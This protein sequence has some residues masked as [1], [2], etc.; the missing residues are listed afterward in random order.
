MN[1]LKHDEYKRMYAVEVQNQ[2][3]ALGKKETDQGSDLEVVDR[4]W[5][6]LKTSM[7]QAAKKVL[8]RKIE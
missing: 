8:Q 5:Q 7:M 1:L 2:Y 6:L 3:E 4:A